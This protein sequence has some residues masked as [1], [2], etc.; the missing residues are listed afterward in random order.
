LNEPKADGISAKVEAHFLGP[1]HER[2]VKDLDAFLASLNANFNED[3]SRTQC[4]IEVNIKM[5]DDVSEVQ[6]IWKKIEEGPLAEIKEKLKDAEYN[7]L[8][9]SLNGN[10]VCL[11]FFTMVPNVARIQLPEELQSGLRD[12]D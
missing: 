11:K 12:V 7:K 8:E 10:I 4:F 1:L 9:A 5:C 6:A 2:L 3:D